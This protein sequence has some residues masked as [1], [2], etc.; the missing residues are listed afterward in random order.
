[1]E[2]DRKYV[3]TRGIPWDSRVICEPVVMFRLRNSAWG[4]STQKKFLLTK[5]RRLYPP[6][7]PMLQKTRIFLSV[8]TRPEPLQRNST[9]TVN[10]S[11]PYLQ[12]VVVHRKKWKQDNSYFSSI[13]SSEEI[14]INV[15]MFAVLHEWA[16]PLRGSIGTTSWT[17]SYWASCNTVNKINRAR[18][19]L[20]L[21]CNGP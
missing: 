13:Q 19:V 7:S 1:M 17:M 3:K 2:R 21:L 15:P 18:K 12:L 16:P 11:L 14:L 8:S 5:F 10:Y 9:S 4:W 6:S 20:H